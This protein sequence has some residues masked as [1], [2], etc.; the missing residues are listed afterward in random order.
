MNKEQTQSVLAL[1]DYK[2]GGLKDRLVIHLNWNKDIPKNR[3]LDLTEPIAEL[4]N[5]IS[6]WTIIHD[7]LNK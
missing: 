4:E 3:Q 5:K 6:H 1:I 7:I 2:I